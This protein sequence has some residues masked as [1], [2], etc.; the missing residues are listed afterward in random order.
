M[1]TV[2]PA[3]GQA[4]SGRL[5]RIDDFNVSLHDARG[6]YHSFTRE[7]ATPK[8]EVKDPIQ[9]HTDLLRIYTDADIH[10]VTAYLVTL[11]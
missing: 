1:V 9:A 10:N 4:V 11:K 5:D 8:V 3:T 6:E 2:T 7:G